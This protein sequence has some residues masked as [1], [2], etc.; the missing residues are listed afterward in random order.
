[1][2]PLITLKNVSKHFPEDG[3]QGITVLTDINLEIFPGEIFTFVGPSG[4][5]KST[6]LRI[7]SGLEK[8]YNG[9]VVMHEGHSTQ[10][11]SFIFQQFAL[12]PWLHTNRA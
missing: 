2:D 7:M 1:M 9:S 3:K 6:L 4:S 11:F 10:D 5:G 12:L 8:Q